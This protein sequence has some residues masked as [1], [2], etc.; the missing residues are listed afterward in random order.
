[1]ENASNIT[2]IA[3]VVMVAL[4]GGLVLAR[5][6]Q[7]PILGYIL[8]GVL[9]GPSGME[10]VHS[11]ES[12]TT[13]ADLGILLLLFGLG[14]ELNLRIFK[15]VWIV[16]TLCTIL[17]TLFSFVICWGCSTIFGWSLG[18]SVLLG[19]VIAL[20]STAVIVKTLE[21]MDSDKTEVGQITIGILIAQDLAIIPM[22]LILKSQN[23]TDTLDISLIFKL[24]VAV[25][26]TVWL[27]RYLGARQ[28][29]RI[30]LT[31]IIAGEKE[32]TPIASLTFCFAAAAISGLMDLSTAYG[33]FLAGLVLGNTHERNI[34][35][36]STKPIQTVLLMVFFLSIGLLVD[37][38]FII[39]NIGMVFQGLMIVTVIKLVLNMSILHALRLPW[40][41]SSLISV[42]LAQLGEFSFLLTGIAF[43]EGIVT[44]FEQKLIISLTVLSLALS[45]FLISFSRYV[46]AKNQGLSCMDGLKNLFRLS[47]FS[48]QEEQKLLDQEE[49]KEII[50]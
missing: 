30:P 9:L 19:F 26:M 38:P 23:A 31:T 20:S 16:T 24:L 14:M 40:A 22:I 32:L 2:E 4:T 43:K 7:P 29:V 50:K 1:M 21:S 10:L 42:M 35:I 27:I 41:Q 3:I 44:E 5:L 8:A 17:Q 6:K 36:D 39:K 15:K 25:G 34:L 33:A 45:P 37:V 49:E 11:R 18:M 12:V 47:F 28:R 48:K 46:Q 13:L